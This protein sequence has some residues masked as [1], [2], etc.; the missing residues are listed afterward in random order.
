MSE[1]IHPDLREMLE[2]FPTPNLD[3]LDAVREGMANS[4]KQPIEENIFVEDKLIEGPD[5]DP[6]RV[7]VYSRNNE[8]KRLPAL[9]WIHGGGYVIGQ[10]EGD[11]GLCQSFVKEEGY[12]IETNCQQIVLRTLNLIPIPIIK[13]QNAKSFS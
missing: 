2:A 12:P 3:Y 13:K 8:T 7:R 1:R 6:L 11:D 4:P 10:P 9:L 5:G